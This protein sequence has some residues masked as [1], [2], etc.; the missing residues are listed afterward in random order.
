MNGNASKLLPGVMLTKPT[1]LIPQ[2]QLGKTQFL[3]MTLTGTINPKL[4]V[5]AGE[6]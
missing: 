6:A 3:T 4:Q 1:W 5:M 2:S